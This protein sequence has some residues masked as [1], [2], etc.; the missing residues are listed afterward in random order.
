[1]ISAG[2]NGAHIRLAPPDRV[3]VV[4]DISRAEVDLHAEFDVGPLQ[5]HLLRQA[6]GEESKCKCE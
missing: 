1:M 4:A 5:E 6:N 3:V 2:V